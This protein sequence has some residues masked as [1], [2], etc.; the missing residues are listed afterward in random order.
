MFRYISGKVR[1]Y[2]FYAALVRNYA[3]VLAGKE[4]PKKEEGTEDKFEDRVEE[5]ANEEPVKKKPQ[6]PPV[7]YRTVKSGW[8][9]RRGVLDHTSN[10]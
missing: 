3:M 2:Y 5:V 4:E 9:Q 10:S 7:D 1:K 6:V 8:S